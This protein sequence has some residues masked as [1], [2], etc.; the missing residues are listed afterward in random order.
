MRSFDIET[1][2]VSSHLEQ[3]VAFGGVDTSAA[4]LVLVFEVTDG[5]VGMSCYRTGGFDIETAAVAGRGRPEA[6]VF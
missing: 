6:I 4:L 2:R 1:P 3:G 5:R